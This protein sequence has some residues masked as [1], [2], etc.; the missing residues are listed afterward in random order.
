MIESCYWKEELKRVASLLRP[1]AKP[2]RW[3]ERRHCVVERDIMIGFFIVRRLI[4]LTKVSQK[5]RDFRMDVYSAPNRGKRVTLLNRGDV[6]ELY[7]I[8]NE[9][10]ETKKPLYLS[11]QFIHAY[12]SFVARDDT[13]NCESMFVVSDFNRNDCIWRVPISAIRALFDLA[14]QDYVYSASFTYNA[15]K[16]DYDISPRSNAA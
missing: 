16:G 6:D 7:D 14:A 1:V 13:R 8:A 10:K 3:T 11:N 2:C 4:E 9:R 12:T 5:V 15:D